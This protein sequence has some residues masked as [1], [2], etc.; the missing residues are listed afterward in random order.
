MIMVD[1]PRFYTNSVLGRQWW[2]HMWTDGPA[3]ELHAFARRIGL[4]R[5]WY[6]EHHVLSHYDLTV[7][8]RERALKEGAVLTDLRKYLAACRLPLEPS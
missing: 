8:M 1:R 2:C 3:E 6:Q 7:C 5:E 4:R